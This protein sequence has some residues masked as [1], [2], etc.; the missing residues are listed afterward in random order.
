MLETEGP[1]K[2]F[3]ENV[4]FSQ[5]KN[6]LV[7]KTSLGNQLSEFKFPVSVKTMFQMTVGS[8][9]WWFSH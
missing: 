8:P 1:E 7:V 2:P 5:S 6:T 4:S 3:I 9:W